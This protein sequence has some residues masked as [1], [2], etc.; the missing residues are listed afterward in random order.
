MFYKTEKSHAD[1]CECDK[2][3]IRDGFEDGQCSED[4]II[5]CHGQEFFEKLKKEGKNRI[6]D[7]L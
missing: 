4:Q 6:F 5:K 7:D 2:P 1:D 3:E